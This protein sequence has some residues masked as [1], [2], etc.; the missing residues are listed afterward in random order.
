MGLGRAL[1]SSSSGVTA[2]PQDDHGTP[3]PLPAQEISGA[4]VLGLSLPFFP[5]GSEVAT[6]GILLFSSFYYKTLPT[7]YLNP[8]CSRKQDSVPS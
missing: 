8:T 4:V 3:L 7:C 5:L 2:S 6:G 1:E